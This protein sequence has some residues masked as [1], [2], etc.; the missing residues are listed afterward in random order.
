MPLIIQWVVNNRLVRPCTYDV[1]DLAESPKHTVYLGVRPQ[2]PLQKF[3]RTG[4]ACS[5][6]KR[7]VDRCYDWIGALD[8]VHQQLQKN[9]NKKRIHIVQAEK[10]QH[11]RNP[12]AANNKNGSGLQRPVVL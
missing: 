10:R 2:I 1:V 12:T 4:K 5:T 9:A 3:S 6:V 11:M 7:R 8:T